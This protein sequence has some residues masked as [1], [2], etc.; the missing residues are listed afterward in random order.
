MI[1]YTRKSVSIAE[2]WFDEDLHDQGIDVIR[3]MQRS[4]PLEK[5]KYREF[6]TIMIDL[7]QDN[8][9]IYK[10]IKRQ[11]KQFLRRAAEEDCLICESCNPEDE[12]IDELAEYYDK[13]AQ[14][15]G[16]PKIDSWKLRKYASRDGLDIS[17]VLDGDGNILTWLVYYKDPGHVRALY[18][19]SNYRKNPDVSY[20]QLVGRAN[21]YLHW[22]DMLRFKEQGIAIYDLGGWYQGNTDSAKLD[23]NRFKEGFGGEIVKT[24]N[25]EFGITPKGKLYLFLNNIRS[26]L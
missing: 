2:F 18:S 1:V 8:D 10:S 4:D 22:Q 9:V 21:R 5:K 7:K 23:I 25:Q 3:V 11:T 13:F 14:I 24:F 16:I 17:R 20:R 19:C 6:Y 15:K 12:T 26:R